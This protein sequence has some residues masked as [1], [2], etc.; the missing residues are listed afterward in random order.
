M[1]T[2]VLNLDNVGMSGELHHKVKKLFGVLQ[3]ILRRKN[4][5]TYADASLYSIFHC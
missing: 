4:K 3:L 1:G 2:R 5:Q